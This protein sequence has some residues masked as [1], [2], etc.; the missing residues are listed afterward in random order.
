MVYYEFSKRVSA[1]DEE[2]AIEDVTQDVSSA[3]RGA[4]HRPP[5]IE[6]VEGVGDG[7]YLVEGFTELYDALGFLSDDDVDGLVNTVKDEVSSDVEGLSITI[8]HVGITATGEVEVESRG[9]RLAFGREM[10]GEE[11]RNQAAKSQVAEKAY[12]KFGT[13]RIEVVD[14]TALGDSRY[15]GVVEATYGRNS[16]VFG[17]EVFSILLNYEPDGAWESWQAHR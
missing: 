13:D 4:D 12:S 3:M 15:R 8:S 9:E 5:S 7:E 17:G 6:T 1:R 14:V 2:E 16:D 10:S 11:R